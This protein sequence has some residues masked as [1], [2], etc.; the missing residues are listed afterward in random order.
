MEKILKVSDMRILEKRVAKGE[1]S[2][3][4][5]VEIINEKAFLQLCNGIQK[6]VKEKTELEERVKT[7]NECWM[8]EIKLRGKN[9]CEIKHLKTQVNNN[10]R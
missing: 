7:L 5:M 8:N 2:Y 3:S 1:I 9:L 4:R 10:V 6:H